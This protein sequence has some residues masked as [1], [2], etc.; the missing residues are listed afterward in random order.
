MSMLMFSVLGMMV[1]LY[2][3]PY[4]VAHSRR[5]QNRNYILVLVAVTG[6]TVVG[7][8]AAFIWAVIDQ[9]DEPRYVPPAPPVVQVESPSPLPVVPVEK[10]CNSGLS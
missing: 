8:I 2:F 7:W 4:M 10:R 1:C 9:Q 5:A 3:L 6:W